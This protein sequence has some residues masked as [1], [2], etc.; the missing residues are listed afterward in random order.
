MVE[1]VEIHETEKAATEVVA[2]EPPLLTYAGDFIAETRG[3]SGQ[4]RESGVG[5]FL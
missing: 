3:G 4:Y 5:R 1:Q 2:Y